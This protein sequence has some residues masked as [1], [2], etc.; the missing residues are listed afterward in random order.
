MYRR[1]ADSGYEPIRP[2]G[3]VFSTSG[4]GTGASIASTGGKTTYPQVREVYQPVM[5]GGEFVP[6]TKEPDE[7]WARQEASDVVYEEAKAAG[8][9]DQYARM[10]SQYM[11]AVPIKKKP[12]TRGAT[13]RISG[14]AEVQEALEKVLNEYVGPAPKVK[15]PSQRSIVDLMKR[16]WSV[17]GHPPVTDRGIDPSF[18]KVCM[19]YGMRPPLPL[20]RGRQD[21]TVEIEDDVL[22]IFGGRPARG[23]RGR[24]G[25]R[26]SGDRR[27]G[28]RRARRTCMTAKELADFLGEFE[29]T[30]RTPSAPKGGKGKKGKAYFDWL[31]KTYGKGKRMR[32][33]PPLCSSGRRGHAGSIKV[34]GR[35]VSIAGSHRSHQEQEIIQILKEHNYHPD[36]VHQVM[37]KGIT[38]AELRRAFAEEAKAAAGG[39]STTTTRVPKT[40]K[41]GTPSGSTTKNGRLRRNGRRRSY[42]RNGFMGEL[43]TVLK[44][45]AVVSAAAIPSILLT[46]LLIQQIQ[47][48][49]FPVTPGIGSA[50]YAMRVRALLAPAVGFSI[51]GLGFAAAG[52]LFPRHRMEIGSGLAASAMWMTT[53]GAWLYYQSISQSNTTPTIPVQK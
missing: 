34:S 45:G 31:K 29:Q 36:F 7:N 40:R 10:L 3:E 39:S 32:K 27:P 11:L 17:E 14:P 28:F 30:S 43:G 37:R 46:S 1:N 47:T 6:R 24:G 5:R 19:Q 12:Y 50:E 2:L 22:E 38:P 26:R 21:D 52:Y 49:I 51:F 33:N 25:G 16:W 42:R 48:R 15:I 44:T 23:R 8:Y 4:S 53:A 18:L 41:V 35:P 9:P 13:P 20:G